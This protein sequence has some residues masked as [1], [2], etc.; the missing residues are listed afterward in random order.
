M[1]V[2]IQICIENLCK[3][4]EKERAGYEYFHSH[5]SIEKPENV[6]PYEA[7]GELKDGLKLPAYSLSV[8]KI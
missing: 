4:C 2:K 1:K 5:N 7:A 3:L 6:K 8:V